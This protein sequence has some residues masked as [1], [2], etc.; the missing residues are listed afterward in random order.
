MAG[1]GAWSLWTPGSAVGACKQPSSSSQVQV[2]GEGNTQKPGNGDLRWAGP[3][4]ATASRV[5]AQGWKQIPALTGTAA[6]P[7]GPTRGRQRTSVLE[8]LRVCG[9]QIPDW[10]RKIP[11][12]RILYSASLRFAIR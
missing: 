8:S 5:W 6:E 10:A 3:E 9:E 7:A 11:E 4:V 2:F 1:V 12:S